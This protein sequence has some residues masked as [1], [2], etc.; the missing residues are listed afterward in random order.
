MQTL[1][2]TIHRVVLPDTKGAAFT[3][4]RN[5]IAFFGN[6]SLREVI[7]CIPGLGEPKYSP[8]LCEDYLVRRLG[9]T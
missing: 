4:Q 8:V 1:K 2:S 9:E 3:P 7:T 6:P 5:S